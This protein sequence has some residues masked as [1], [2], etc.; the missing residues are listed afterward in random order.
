[1]ASQ[2]TFEG[3]REGWRRPDCACTERFGQGIFVESE[4]QDIVGAVHDDA[5]ATEA[6]EDLEV[7]LRVVGADATAQNDGI[8][9]WVVPPRRQCCDVAESAFSVKEMA[10]IGGRVGGDEA[11][12]LWAMLFPLCYI[13]DGMVAQGRRE[14]VLNLGE[15]GRDYACEWRREEALFAQNVVGNAHEQG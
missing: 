14:G 12:E 10:L 4:A 13:E 15:R 2:A 6:T 3:G 7:G 1:M 5:A 8:D 9:V 11:S